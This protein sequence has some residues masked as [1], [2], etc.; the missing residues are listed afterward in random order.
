MIAPRISLY[1][2]LLLL[3]HPLAMR[4]GAQ[5]GSV[6]G[7]F[8]DATG[9]THTWFINAAN[10]LVWDATPYLPVGGSF[11][12]SSLRAD[13]TD[14]DWKQDDKAIEV[15]RAHGAVDI[16]IRPTASAADIPATAWQRLVDRLETAGLRYGIAFGSGVP[17]PLAGIVVRPSS[18]RT[19]RIEAGSE[20][21]WPV[22]DATSAYWLMVNETG[23]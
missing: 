21:T 13:A 10:A 16:L 11:T 8:K 12:P 3:A 9:K 18:Y 7:E 17:N 19:S 15:L 4:A 5:T 14:D 1:L 20:A 22:P 23:R 6:R 2:I